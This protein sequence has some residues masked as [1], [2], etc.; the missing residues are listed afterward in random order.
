MSVLIETGTPPLKVGRQATLAVLALLIVALAAPAMGADQAGGD[1]EIARLIDATT[2]PLPIMPI[3]VPQLASRKEVDD[4]LATG[5][6]PTLFQI[7]QP[8]GQFADPAKVQFFQMLAVEYPLKVNFRKVAAGSGAARRLY[9]AVTKPVYLLCDPAKSGDERCGFIDEAIFGDRDV[10]Q[11]TIEDLI[12]KRLG[13]IPNLLTTF[14]LTAANEKNV[15]FE[16]HPD[17]PNPGP[18]AT[19]I[20]VLFFPGED[21]APGPVNRLRELIALERFFYSNRLRI[22]ECDLSTAG[23]VYR[24]LLQNAANGAIP[25]KPEL[26]LVNP[27]TR[28]YV[29]YAPEGGSPPVA[30]LTRD[31]FEAWLA[32]NGVA[33]PPSGPLDAEAAW[34]ELARLEHQT[35]GN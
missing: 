32:K 8:S 5:N 4:I 7:S 19:W 35:N 9:D 26:W 17:F 10:N 22:A 21:T 20:A 33:R 25:T 30:G 12:H 31:A 18:T 3:A 16:Y 14:S 34:R 15:V 24:A 6:L 1:A 27:A 13:I 29:K 11:T 23:E 2:H 28:H